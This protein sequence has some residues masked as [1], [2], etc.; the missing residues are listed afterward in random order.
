VKGRNARVATTQAHRALPDAVFRVAARVAGV[1][2][3]MAITK[4]LI[5][6]RAVIRFTE[7]AKMVAPVCGPSR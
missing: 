5:S 3:V 1:S 7:P 2:G 4:C 6:G